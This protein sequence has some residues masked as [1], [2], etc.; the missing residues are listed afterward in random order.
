MSSTPAQELARDVI[1]SLSPHITDVVL[2]PGSRNSP[3]SL[4]VLSR[5]DLR[6]H[7][8][9]DERSA[10]FL[11]LGLARIQRRPVPVIMTSGTAVSNCLPAV[12][13]AA[14]AETA[15]AVPARKIKTA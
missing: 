2:C 10:A 13:E 1:E 9:I 6:V 8:R 15:V 14:A 3:L 7:V 4:E 11:A 5:D 12:T